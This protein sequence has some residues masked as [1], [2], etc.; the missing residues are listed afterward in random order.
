MADSIRQRCDK[1]LAQLKTER[2]SFET[3]WRELGEFFMPMAPRFLTS[4]RN[5]GDRRN[6][7]I[8]NNTPVLA[9]DTL[10]S[11]M[12]GGMTS[13]ARPWFSLTTSDTELAERAAV[14]RGCTA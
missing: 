10:G 9:A 3:S 13:P 2:N 12:H 5:K 4:E 6:T 11:G 7:K 1:R 8:I 14:K